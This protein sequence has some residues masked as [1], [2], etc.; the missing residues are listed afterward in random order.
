MTPELDPQTYFEQ[1]FSKLLKEDFHQSLDCYLKGLRISKNI[2]LTILAPKFV[3][4]PEIK[5]YIY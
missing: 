2:D 1:G 4:K 5:R 3:L